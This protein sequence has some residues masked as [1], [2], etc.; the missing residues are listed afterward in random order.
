MQ[1]LEF[2]KKSTSK[3]QKTEQKQELEYENKREGHG[4][5]IA[6][7]R[8]VLRI[9]NS[10]TFYIES[11]STNNLFYFV[12]YEPYFQ[13]CSCLD[14]STRHVRCKHLFAIE[15]AIRFGTLK[16]I[17]KLPKEAKRYPTSISAT[18]LYRDE[19]YDF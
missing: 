15:F 16:D 5:N 8:K 18:K 3:Y 1:R 7:I 2:A 14:N 17:D 6:L 13:W 4:L 10:D 9:E 11:E 12:R 19:E